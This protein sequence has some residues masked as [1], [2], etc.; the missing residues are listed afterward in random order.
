MV[1]DELGEGQVVQHSLLETNS[2]WHM[3]K[4]IEHFVRVN[5]K[6]KL[7]RVIIVD[8]ELNE[9]RCFEKMF[10]EVRML[11]VPT[12]SSRGW[13]R[14]QGSQSMER[15]MRRITKRSTRCVTT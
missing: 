13:Q 11:S 6:T 3:Y 2:D 10:P 9:I 5:E 14:C 12:M 8:K 4:A 1:M 7:L 15:S